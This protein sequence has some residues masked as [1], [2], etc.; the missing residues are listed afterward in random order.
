MAQQTEFLNARPN[1]NVS[2]IEVS[3]AFYRDLLGFQA[4]AMMGEPP[5]F[6][7]L[8]RGGAQRSGCYIYVRGVEAIHD[9]FKAAGAT[10]TFPLTV[11]PWGLRDFVVQD[12]DGHG[13][14]IGEW[15]GG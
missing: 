9:V 3:V 13:I 15:V 11:Q 10:F 1:L 14:A 5:S 8:R 12:P 4:E 7:L 2:N 6:A